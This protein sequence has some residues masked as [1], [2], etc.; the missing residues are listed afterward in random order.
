MGFPVGLGKMGVTVRWQKL[1]FHPIFF[2]TLP[3]K[4]WATDA[5]GRWDVNPFQP[6]ELT[7]WIFCSNKRLLLEDFQWLLRLS[8]KGSSFFPLNDVWSL[9]LS[10]I[11]LHPKSPNIDPIW[12]GLTKHLLCATHRWGSRPSL[13]SWRLPTAP[14]A[15]PGSL[16]ERQ[17]RS[18][19]WGTGADSMFWQDPHWFALGFEVLS[20]GSQTRL[21]GR[22]THTAGPHPRVSDSGGPRW[23]RELAWQ[24]LVMLV[25]GPHWFSNLPACW[26]YLGVVN[27]AD[28]WVPPPETGFSSVVCGLGTEHLKSSLGDSDRQ[29]SL[30]TPALRDQKGDSRAPLS[31]SLTELRD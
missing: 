30:G 8:V 26:H 6:I 17:R 20:K 11:A 31:S 3:T 18:P 7:C 12:Q 22:V 23:T 1:H 14:A 28:T 19:T 16:R 13:L 2:L 21:E 27:N 9:V 4:K 15:S 10:R 29:Q 24:V 25:W 5:R